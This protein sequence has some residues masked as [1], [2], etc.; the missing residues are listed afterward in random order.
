MFVTLMDSPGL[1]FFLPFSV[2]P[3][4]FFQMIVSLYSHL[5]YTTSG[6]LL[7]SIVIT[8]LGTRSVKETMKNFHNGIVSDCNISILIQI[9]TYTKKALLYHVFDT[10]YSDIIILYNIYYGTE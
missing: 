9:I 4:E 5:K 3:A 2:S 10:Q 7:F 6:L 1:W 8:G